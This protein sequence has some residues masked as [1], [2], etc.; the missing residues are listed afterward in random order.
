MRS[1]Q[2]INETESEIYVDV[3]DE[4]GL[5]Y[6]THFSSH[7]QVS[8]Y[9]V[10]GEEFLILTEEIGQ[11]PWEVGSELK[12]VGN[13]VCRKATTNFRGRK[14][15]VWFTEEIPIP[16]GPW[17]LNG[18]PGLITEAEDE[19]KTFYFYLE[20]ISQYNGPVAIKPPAKGTKIQ[21]WD[22]Y[23]KLVKTRLNRLKKYLESQ[24]GIS[25]NISLDN[26]IEK[27]DN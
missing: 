13:F 4:E 24:E 1:I 22:E 10:L 8:R 14:W 27:I 26:T 19:T 21:G 6:Y 2:F 3:R 11:I 15:N 16:A 25:V 7:K 17:K 9:Y 5:S 20:K 23:C 18:L 12:K